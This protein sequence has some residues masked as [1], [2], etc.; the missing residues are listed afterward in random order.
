MCEVIAPQELAGTIVAIHSLTFGSLTLSE[1]AVTDQSPG[2]GQACVNGEP[3]DASLGDTPVTVVC[4]DDT[5]VGGGDMDDVTDEASSDETN[6][7]DDGETDVSATPAAAGTTWCEYSGTCAGN[8]CPRVNFGDEVK[9]CIGQTGTS[10]T[11]PTFASKWQ[12]KNKDSQFSN[13]S[14]R[15]SPGGCPNNDNKYNFKWSGS[16]IT[17]SQ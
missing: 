15:D 4:R 16:N 3:C 9:F 12:V 2:I 13:L 7:G 11:R 10:C 5:C 6:A 17:C 14:F 8:D 1:T